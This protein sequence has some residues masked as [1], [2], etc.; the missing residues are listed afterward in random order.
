M[1]QYQFFVRIL[2]LFVL[3]K[4]KAGELV[5]S[6]VHIER[7]ITGQFL[8]CVYGEMLSGKLVVKFNALPLLEINN[9]FT[10]QNELLINVW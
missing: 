3:T 9:N 7:V 1:V 6:T 5:R 2:F 8:E 4:D 10:E